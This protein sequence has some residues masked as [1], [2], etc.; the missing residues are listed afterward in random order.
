[1]LT[2]APSVPVG[3]CLAKSRERIRGAFK[4]TE[5]C[6]SQSS[7]S[8]DAASSASKIAALLTSKVSGPK[9]AMASAASLPSAAAS[10]RSEGRHAPCRLA[11]SSSPLPP[12]HACVSPRCNAERHNSRRTQAS[13]RSAG[14]SL[15]PR[16]SRAP[17]QVKLQNQI[18]HSCPGFQ[19]TEKPPPICVDRDHF[20]AAV[21]RQS[22]R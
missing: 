21:I 18:R 15:L 8:K 10:R 14:L 11:R 16:P 9:I 5:K 17:R 1:M 3:N 4:F 13:R 7:R 19:T 22:N 20:D 2:I 6:A 12:R